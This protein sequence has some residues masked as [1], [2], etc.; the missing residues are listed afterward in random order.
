M[1]ATG[2]DSDK[3]SHCPCNQKRFRAA[4]LRMHSA[5]GKTQTQRPIQRLGSPRSSGSLHFSFA[6]LRFALAGGSA[7]SPS[8]P[9]TV[10]FRRILGLI[11]A[12]ASMVVKMFPLLTMLRFWVKIAE[13]SSTGTEKGGR[14][15]KTTDSVRHRGKGGV[16]PQGFDG[17]RRR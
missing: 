2:R 13:R 7:L 3:L 4:N 10:A 15:E 14:V 17:F 12:E 9:Q 6:S 16:L 1:Q 5:K 11:I 8:T